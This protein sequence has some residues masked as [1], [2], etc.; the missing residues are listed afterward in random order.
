MV[1]SASCSSREPAFSCQH[2]HHEAFNALLLHSEESNI[3]FWLPLTL[4]H[5]CTHIQHGTYSHRYTQISIIGLNILTKRQLPV[6]VIWFG[7]AF[8]GNSNYIWLIFYIV[9]YLYLIQYK[10]QLP[11]LLFEYIL[12]KYRYLSEIVQLLWTVGHRSKN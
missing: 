10:K 11:V 12:R 7:I 6:L 1:A 2:S 4:G 3:L 8:T 5:A 9:S